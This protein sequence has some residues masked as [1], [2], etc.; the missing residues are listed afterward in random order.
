VYAYFETSTKIRVP[1]ADLSLAFD[2][3]SVFSQA[4]EDHLAVIDSLRDQP[5]VL[6]GIAEEMTR[7]ILAGKKIL[8]CGSGVA[9]CR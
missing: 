5:S 6:Q 8:R 3:S 7:A 9:P 2:A 1:G 4:I